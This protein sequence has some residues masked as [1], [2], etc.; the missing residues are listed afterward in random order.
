MQAIAWQAPSSSDQDAEPRFPELQQAA[1][2]TAVSLLT[3]RADEISSQ[4]E[5][6]GQISDAM[7]KAAQDAGRPVPHTAI[8][9]RIARDK[10]NWYWRYRDYYAARHDFGRDVIW[11]VVRSKAKEGMP[12]NAIIEACTKGLGYDF[13]FYCKDRG[14]ENPLTDWNKLW[15]FIENKIRS[16]SKKLQSKVFG[17]KKRGAQLSQDADENAFKFYRLIQEGYSMLDAAE[18]MGG[19]GRSTQYD[20]IKRG[21]RVAE[22]RQERFEQMVE[23]EKRHREVDSESSEQLEGISTLE[24]TLEDKKTTDSASITY[25]LAGHEEKCP[26]GSTEK[27]R[28]RMSKKKRK[29]L[30]VPIFN[31]DRPQ[32]EFRL[33]AEDR[34]EALE[35][36][37][38]EDIRAISEAVRQ[39]ELECGIYWPRD[40]HP[41][42]MRL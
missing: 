40:C 30:K 11:E 19:P 32:R 16:A 29:K 24:Y 7:A 21:K 31:R 17:G 6:Q 42:T 1:S 28:P 5:L 26:Q 8:L 18:Q 2:R 35:P 36:E 25:E 33:S 37:S 23:Q 14:I 20:W 39:L 3:Y 41:M 12:T 34:A 22:Q 9:D 15:C 27:R 38:E 13:I 10:A 4:S